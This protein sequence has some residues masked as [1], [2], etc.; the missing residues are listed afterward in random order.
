MKVDQ[1]TLR[2]MNV[3]ILQAEAGGSL[4]TLAK[5]A[6]TSQSYLSQCVGKGAF[7]DVGDEV[8]RRLEF[9]MGKPHGWLDEPHIP[10][11]KHAKAQAVFDQLLQLPEYKIDAVIDLLD[12][13]EEEA[14]GMLG[15]VSKSAMPQGRD[16]DR[17]T[18][19]KD[20]VPKRQQGNQP[21]RKKR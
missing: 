10:D 11:A 8:A 18:V 4:T 20:D 13:R 21:A 19:L 6:G 9:A 3:R 1:R 12:M 5:K 2:K 17:V 16:G 7:R 14:I 15:R